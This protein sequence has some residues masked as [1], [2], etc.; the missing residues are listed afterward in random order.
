MEEEVN[1]K[2]RNKKF[3]QGLEEER[4]R[5]PRIKFFAEGLERIN[6][7]SDGV[8]AI[9]ITLLV[10][11]IH[12]PPLKSVD[13][14]PNGLWSL[15]PKILIYCLSFLVIGVYWM[16][17]H[18][19]FT[20]IRR[21]D[22]GLLWLNN[23]FLLT[24]AFQ[25]FPTGLLGDYGDTTAGVAFYAGCQILTSIFKLLIWIYAS[26]KHRLID[27][28]LDNRFIIYSTL[29]SISTVFVFALSFGLAFVDNNI[30][31][32]SWFLLT[33]DGPII[34]LFY[35]PEPPKKKGEDGPDQQEVPT[36][37]GP[38]PTKSASTPAEV[39]PGAPV[40]A[41]KSDEPTTNQ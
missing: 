11:D 5:R 30:A 7:F 21:Y 1:K 22:A 39:Q 23:L 27:P 31:K 2:P 20:Y 13:D 6:A 24:I 38:V 34:R 10:L 29:Q 36:A 19:I 3:S 9:A 16:L 25:P 40:P 35:P 12:L 8:F 17:H 33:I 37:F 26:Y 14:L 15:T 32:F 41:K 28:D 4:Y 18:G